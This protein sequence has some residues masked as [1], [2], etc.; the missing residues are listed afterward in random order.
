[1]AGLQKDAASKIDEAT[2]A[3]VDVLAVMGQPNIYDHSDE[4]QVSNLVSKMGEE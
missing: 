2:A 3:L 1:M 4:S